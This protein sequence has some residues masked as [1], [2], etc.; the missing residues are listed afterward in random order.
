MSVI[1]TVSAWF[2]DLSFNCV[3]W[4]CCSSR[5]LFVFFIKARFELSV[6]HLFLISHA[7]SLVL[8]PSHWA[9]VVHTPWALIIRGRLLIFVIC[10]DCCSPACTLTLIENL[11]MRPCRFGLCSAHSCWP[12]IAV[13]CQSPAPWAQTLVVNFWTRLN[14]LCFYLDASG[15]LSL[16]KFTDT[17]R[18]KLYQTR[19]DSYADECFAFVI[20]WLFHSHLHQQRWTSYLTLHFTE[21][22]ARCRA[23]NGFDSS[24][25]PRWSS[26]FLINA[27]KCNQFRVTLNG[28]PKCTCSYSH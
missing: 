25:S 27:E 21:S 2:I 8:Q 24:L 19:R 5:T 15:M 17:V 3:F 28:N 18:E 1:N 12:G 13:G 4:C 20:V 14:E 7:S 26:N 11:Q 22:W 10:S 6:S 23:I 9:S 16:W